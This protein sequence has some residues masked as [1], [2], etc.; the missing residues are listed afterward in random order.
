MTFLKFA[1]LLFILLNLIISILLVKL[2]KLQKRGW[3]FADIAF[4][5][6]AVEFYLITDKAYYHS[7]LPH[8][9]LALS[10]L[11]I[12]IASLF[13]WKKRDFTYGR[14]FKLFWR[15]GFL[16]TFLIYLAMT[17]SLFLIKN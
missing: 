9:I 15:A 8:L 13:L 17:I 1:S 2:L 5:L 11:A 10:I 16:L 4:P 6:F 3:N 7:F 12:V 14:F